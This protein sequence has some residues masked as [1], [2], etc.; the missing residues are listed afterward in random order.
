MLQRKNQKIIIIYDIKIDILRLGY[1]LNF[2]MFVSSVDWLSSFFMFVIC[3]AN[4][5]T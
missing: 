2:S 5:T 1:L 3:I 4:E